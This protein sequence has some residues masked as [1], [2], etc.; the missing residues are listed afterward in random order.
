[1]KIITKTK[2]TY[3]QSKEIG[4]Y[5]LA[6]AL[7]EVMA[8]GAAGFQA[9]IKIM[10]PM[11]AFKSRIH[12]MEKIMKNICKEKNIE[13]VEMKSERSSVITQTMVIV[14]VT[15]HVSSSEEKEPANAYA[16]QDIILTKWIGMEGMLRIATEK[17]DA[18]KER[19]SAGFMKQI[20]SYKDE[21]FAER[22][23]H[24]AKEAGTLLMRQIAEGGVL[25]ALWNLAKETETGIEADLK[26]LPVRQET[27]E[28]C[29]YFHLNPYQLTSAGSM[30]MVTEDG[31]KLVEAMHAQEIPA[32]IIGRLT[33]NNDKILH[34]GE[35]I[36]YIDRPAPD[37]LMKIFE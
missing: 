18:L 6:S 14:T 25:A 22:E 29:E 16:G 12:T 37:D 17:E 5:A 27:I 2:V 7:N 31:D 34:N 1:M 3:G 21:I 8:E 13:L 28:V 11:F 4:I 36:R 9:Q 10:I 15:G 33:D 35:E 23:I 30:L 32:T 19:F 24:L 20:M 26:Q